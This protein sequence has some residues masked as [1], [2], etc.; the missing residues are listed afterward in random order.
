M[1]LRFIPINCVKLNLVI[2]GE[3]NDM[4]LVFWIYFKAVVLSA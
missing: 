2:E 3:I 4:F 1:I